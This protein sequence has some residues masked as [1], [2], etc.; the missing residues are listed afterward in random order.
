MLTVD[1]HTHVFPDKIASA[2]ISALAKASGATP[3]L[4]GT[5]SGLRD[6]AR[7]ADV[8]IAV[9]LPVLTKPSQFDSVF[10]YAF[11]VNCKFNEKERT[12]IL[13]FA[14]IHPDCD[15]VEGKLKAVKDAGFLGIKI[16]PDYQGVFIDDE[17]YVKII[18]VAKEHGL[19]VV[20]HSGV[21]EGFLDMPVR[22]TPRRALNLLDKVGGYNKL[23]FAHLG[24]NRLFDEV[25][26]CL[27]GKD[28]YF[29]TGYSLDQI[30]NEQF[31]EL[32]KKH[33]ANKI[34]FATD[35]PWRDIATEKDRVLATA[36]TDEE[37]ELILYKNALKL[38]NLENY[39]DK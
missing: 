5:E 20:T 24:A 18:K 12:N 10:K 3:F 4:D 38:L 23:V 26:S 28:V 19:I 11:S 27:A 36:L 34:L 22:C 8:Y 15:D 1:F 25:L 29:D 37:K 2:S 13:S 14:G 33:G 17:R 6:G 35:S 31:L 7:K 21:D 30:S 39:N 16:H 9:A 32:V